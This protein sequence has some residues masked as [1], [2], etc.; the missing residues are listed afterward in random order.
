MF[1]LLKKHASNLCLMLD[2]GIKYQISLNL[3]KCVFCVPFGI[4]LGHIFY[5]QGLMVDPTKIM[6]I[7]NMEIPENVKKF[8]SILGHT[9]YYRKFIQVYT[10]ITAPMENLLN[11]DAT[12]CWDED[13]QK[14][15]ELLKENMVNAPILVKGV[16]CAC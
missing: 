2:T 9:G 3:K 5:Q 12:F 8:F 14:S 11:K 6:I 16:S 15:F 4:L 7:V 1:G 13:F 10:L